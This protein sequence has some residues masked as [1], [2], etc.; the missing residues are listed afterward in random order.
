MNIDWESLGKRLI[1]ANFLGIRIEQSDGHRWICVDTN[2][3][4]T[5]KCWK[6]RERGFVKQ[7]GSYTA[8]LDHIDAVLK[9]NGEKSLLDQF[10]QSIN[11]YDDLGVVFGEGTQ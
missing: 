5:P 2:A 10:N 9:E 4:F 8:A 11:Y 3:D 6:L 1:A 7:Y